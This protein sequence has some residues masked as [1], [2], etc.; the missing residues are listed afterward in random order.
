MKKLAKKLVKKLVKTPIFLIK[1]PA[2]IPAKM[3]IPAGTGTGTKTSNTG[4]Y[5]GSAGIPAD[6]WSSAV[7]ALVSERHVLKFRFIRSVKN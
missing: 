3:V 5:P 2:K 6:P 1:I 7:P 4:R